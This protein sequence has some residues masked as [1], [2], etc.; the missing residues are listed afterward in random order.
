MMVI[1]SQSSALRPAPPDAHVS[2]ASPLLAFATTALLAACTSK[3]QKGA[4]LRGDRRHAD[5]R[6]ARR[7]GR[8][9]F[10]RSST[11]RPASWFRTRSSTVWPRSTPSSRQP[12]TRVSRRDSPRAGRG[13][14]TPCRSPSRSIRA[15]VGTMASR[16]R[17]ATFATAFKVF[18]DPKVASPSRRRSSRTSTRC[19]SRLAHRRGVVQEAHAGAVLRRRVSALRSCRSTC[20]VAFRSTAAHV[21]ADADADRDRPFPLRE[22]GAGRAHRARCR[23]GELPRPPKARS[24]HLR[25]CRS[26]RP[27]RAQIL[28]G[29]GRLHG[30]FPARPAAR[31]LDS[32]TVA[33]PIVRAELQYAFMAMNPLRPQSQRT[34]R[35]RS[36]ATCAFGARCRWRSIARRCCKTSSATRAACPRPVPDDASRSPTARSTHRRSTPPPP[37]RCSTP[38]AGARREWNAHEERPPLRFS[39]M[40]PSA[41]ATAHALC[42]VA[43]GAIPTAWRAGRPRRRSTRH[44]VQRSRRTTGRLRRDPGRLRHGPEPE[45][46]AA[47]LG[48]RRASGRTGRTFCATPTPRSTRC[49]TAR[50]RRSIRRR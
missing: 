35:T 31:K 20:T 42:G 32:S 46:H 2:C 23:H 8:S 36:S 10:R 38:P 44:A 11:K 39:L 12:A 48:D 13:R 16:S 9:S 7:R 19:R 25:P 26:R 1:V 45:R 30:G 41:S 3:D 37:R 43:P 24:R 27:P 22:V 28:S 5:L 49:S 15:R 29:P 50:R 6:G 33:R 17:R 47:E 40:R 18:T 14:P 4:V 34:A 21:G